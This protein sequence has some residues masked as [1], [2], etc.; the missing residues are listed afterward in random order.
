MRI[1]K[2]W[3]RTRKEKKYYKSLITIDNPKRGWST[4]CR[5]DSCGIEFNRTFESIRFGFDL[6]DT[7]AMSDLNKELYADD[8]IRNIISKKTSDWYSDTTNRELVSNITSD[9][10]KDPAYAEK[11]RMACQKRSSDPKYRQKLSDNAARG[12]LHAIKT[13]CGLR[14]INLSDFDA[15]LS[16]I[17]KIERAKFQPIS[18][19]CLIKAHYTCD[20]CNKRGVKFN[21]HHLDGWNWCIEKRFD[22]DN[23]VCLCHG[24]HSEFHKQ[25]GQ[26][27]NTRKQYDE[28]KALKANL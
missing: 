17:N 3:F 15:F 20:I 13:S 9:R 26:G 2:Y 5:C 23:L 11:H 6:C 27:N 25:Y 7:C 24:C 1:S 21:A 16:D 12:R 22:L 19:E 14:K 4:R 8:G 28:F 10:Y 18:Q